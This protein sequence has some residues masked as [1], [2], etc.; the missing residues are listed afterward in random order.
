MAKVTPAIPAIGLPCASAALP[1]KFTRRGT[2]ADDCVDAPCWAATWEQN[3]EIVRNMES[4]NLQ[5][6]MVYLNSSRFFFHT[7]YLAL[8]ALYVTAKSIGG[9]DHRTR[10]LVQQ[11]EARG[12]PVF[13]VWQ[14]KIV[15]GSWRR[16]LAILR[17]ARE[18]C[19]S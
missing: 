16:C 7:R 4:E 10:N 15:P 5:D 3:I 8:L 17:Q 14:V 13:S 12:G 2:G 1:V 19:V 11:R 9:F 18:W 6:F